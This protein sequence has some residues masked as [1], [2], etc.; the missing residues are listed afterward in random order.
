MSDMFRPIETALDEV[1]AR[2]DA[3][4]TKINYQR[5]EAKRLHADAEDADDLADR[6]TTIRDGY[7]R[8]IA[9]PSV[10]YNINAPGSG[11]QKSIGE[12]IVR[13][14]RDFEGGQGSTGVVAMP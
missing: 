9:T 1:A 13:H 3:L 14:V 6:L 5:D 7:K 2:I 11:N 8:L 12:E 10:T 4:E